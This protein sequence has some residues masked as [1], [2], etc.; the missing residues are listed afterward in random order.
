MNRLNL[1]YG[2]LK[3][4]SAAGLATTVAMLFLAGCRTDTPVVTTEYPVAKVKEATFDRRD[5]RFVQ[6][7]SSAVV[8]LEEGQEFAL[9]TGPAALYHLYRENQQQ[10]RDR[11]PMTPLYRITPEGHVFFTDEDGHLNFVMPPPGGVR[12]P[13]EQASHYRNFQGFNRSESGR[14]LVGLVI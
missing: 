8:R 13:M 9:L 6:G 12:I 7:D 4:H 14:D 11:V 3:G 10:L 2:W 1:G 5:I